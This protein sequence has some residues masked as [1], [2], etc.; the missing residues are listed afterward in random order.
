[1]PKAMTNIRVRFD[2]EG[3]ESYVTI[4]RDGY[5]QVHQPSNGSIDHTYDV[6][7]MQLLIDIAKC[8]D[9]YRDQ[10]GE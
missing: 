1:M 4:E 8:V 10:E 5:I 6:I 3:G 7:E 2:G 9:R